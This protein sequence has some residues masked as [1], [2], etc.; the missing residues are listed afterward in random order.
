[1]IQQ[2]EMT[3][4]DTVTYRCIQIDSEGYA[5]LKNILHEQGRPKKYYRSIVPIFKMVN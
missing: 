2:G 3:I 4:I 1:M 5:H